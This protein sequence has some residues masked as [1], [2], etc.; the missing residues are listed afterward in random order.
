MLYR[1]I[2]KV[3]GSYLLG[4]SGAFILPLLIAAYYQ[5]VQEPSL[6]PQPHTT[7]DFLLSFIFTAFLGAGFY[8]L[9]RKVPGH[10]YR[11]EALVLVIVIW[12]LTP[13]VSA[14]PFYLSNTLKNPVQAYFEAV[15]GLTTT[16]ATVLQ[17]KKFD[18]QNG[19]EIPIEKDVRGSLDVRYSYY[20]NVDPI[21]DKMTGQVLYQGVEALGKGLLFWRSFMQFLG[22]GGIVLLFI[23]I[24]PAIGLGGKML[25]QAELSG[26]PAQGSM[27]PRIKENAYQIWK[28][29]MGLT[30]LQVFILLLTNSELPLFDAVTISFSTLATGGFTIHNHSIGFYQNVNTDWVILIFMLLGSISFS[31]YFYILRGK[32]YKLYQPEFIIFI[33]VAISSCLICTVWLYN[34]ER[35]FFGSTPGLFSL[36]DAFRYGSFQIVSMLT[37]TGF[38]IADYDYWPY[39]IQVMMLILMFIGGMSGSTAGGLKILRCYILSRIGVHTIESIFRPETVRQLRIADREINSSTATWVLSFFLTLIA[40]SVLA[41]FYYVISG[42]DPETALGLVAAMMTNTG[43]GFRVVGPYDSFAFLSDTGL[44]VS[45]FL[46]IL[47]RLEIFAVLAIFV[48]A[49]WRT[50]S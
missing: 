2:S 49:F 6:H 50:K 30:I 15:S 24:L 10:L 42:L 43:I 20:G 44:L 39:P 32:F 22:G 18:P 34:T 46:M 14:L 16:G 23:A 48:P 36:L 8:F 40:I 1:D 41:T 33:A 5:Y 3:L 38:A 28:I 17:A 9:G 47:G 26:N 37:T 13:F 21:V 11:R 35:R 12:I 19:Q 27:T 29:Y 31:L 45:A 4:F 25:F 7:Q